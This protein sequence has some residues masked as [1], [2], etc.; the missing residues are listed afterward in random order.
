[1]SRHLSEIL[2]T[3]VEQES[4]DS[5]TTA[6][7]AAVE[8]RVLAR[9]IGR[10]RA[11]R[12]GAVSLGSAAAVIGVVAGVQAL[13]SQDEPHPPAT[14]S[15]SP[16]PAPTPSPSPTPSPNPT[17]TPT[18]AAL[19]PVTAHPL[20]PDAQAM[21][22][23][24]F[25]ST[26]EGW[27]LLQRS[28]VTLGEGDGPIE[29][30]Y[31]YLVDPAGTRYEVPF[32][33]DRSVR[34]VDWRP[35]TSTAVVQ[36]GG[37][38]DW[39]SGVAVMDLAEGTFLDLPGVHGMP[40]LTAAG[41]VVVAWEDTLAAYSTDGMR[42]AATQTEGYVIDVELD[43]GRTSLAVTL[44]DAGVLVLTT[45]LQP[46]RP[47]DATT[48]LVDHSCVSVTWLDRLTLAAGCPDDQDPDRL[49]YWTVPL[50]G[51]PETLPV[52]SAPVWAPLTVLRTGGETFVHQPA[53]PFS[54]PDGQTATART[55]RIAPDGTLVPV[56]PA[57]VQPEATGG[58]IIGRRDL[59]DGRAGELVALDT[60]T[61]STV[62]VM[63][64]GPGANVAPATRQGGDTVSIVAR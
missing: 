17:T 23:G 24:T 36:L 4:H 2:T 51:P 9:R 38:G 10:R 30:A 21:P 3:F 60:R 1:M 41:D 40:M 47:S 42:L 26:G 55:S 50:D 63:P 62:V 39:S 35:G 34:L 18:E 48:H 5:A 61:G 25:E 58:L 64:D 46:V 16:S 56:E 11:L 6:P 37:P 22:A 33:T 53:D 8:A 52:G 19:P 20:L 12:T 15:P 54:V 28:L 45:D 44:Q 43:P 29:R 13:T 27:V 31:F 7:E 14:E 59:G 57:L 32:S 49:R